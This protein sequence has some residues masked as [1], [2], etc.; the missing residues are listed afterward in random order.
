MIW[1]PPKSN[2]EVPY[3]HLVLC[4]KRGGY[5]IAIDGLRGVDFTVVL[6]DFRML[7]CERYVVMCRGPVGQSIT[8]RKVSKL[9]SKHDNLAMSLLRSYWF[10]RYN[11]CMC[12]IW[13]IPHNLFIVWCRS[14]RNWY[15]SYHYWRDRN[16]IVHKVRMWTYKFIIVC[17]SIILY[18]QKDDLR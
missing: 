5:R 13:G 12:I 15:F 14:N 8:W 4:S 10:L 17:Q 3:C 2:N 18:P 6:I 7:R 9:T 11:V 1:F 16:S